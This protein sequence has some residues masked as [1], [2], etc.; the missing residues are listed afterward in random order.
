MLILPLPSYIKFT[1]SN[2][3]TVITVLS[4]V[5][6][7]YPIRSISIVG[8]FYIKIKCRSSPCEDIMSK[9]SERV[10]VILHG[11]FTAITILQIPRINKITF[12]YRYEFSNKT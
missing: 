5:L 9:S 3:L 2:T 6:N 4:P 7:I 1:I 11:N 10:M 12:N 8:I